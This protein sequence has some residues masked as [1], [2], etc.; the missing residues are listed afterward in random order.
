MQI[1]HHCTLCPR[2]CGADR[3]AGQ[4]LLAKA[5]ANLTVDLPEAMLDRTAGRTA[6]Q[7]SAAFAEQTTPCAWPAPPCTTGRSRA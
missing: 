1:P 7:G 5:G 6:P 3:A 4:E 2:A